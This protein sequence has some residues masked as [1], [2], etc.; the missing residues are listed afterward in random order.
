[1][2]KHFL[3]V[4][5]RLLARRAPCCPEVN[6]HDLARLKVNVLRLLLVDV[7]NIS[8]SGVWSTNSKLNLNLDVSSL[9]VDIF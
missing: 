7:V 6:E 5:H 4:S 1:M 2:L 9:R 8:N 3:V